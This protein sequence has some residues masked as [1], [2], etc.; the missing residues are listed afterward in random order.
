MNRAN[1]K[2]PI[3]LVIVLLFI[4]CNNDNNP[5]A[6]E[7]LVDYAKKT[8]LSL[9]AIKAAINNFG[10]EDMSELAQYDIDV[11][12]INYYT[13]Y[14]GNKIIVSGVISVPFPVNT[15]LPVLAAHR[16][17][18]FAHDEAP[19]K[20]FIISGYEIFS[21][22][23]FV[24]V[25]PDMIGFGASEQYVHPYYNYEYSS[26]CALDMIRAGK[27]FM[28]KIKI[29]GSKKLFL[30]GYS[31]GGY[32][33]TAAHKALEE[34]G[35]TELTVTA[36][37]TGAGSYNPV[38]VMRD[39]AAREIFTSPSYLA[40]IIY[41]YHDIYNW[42]T[43]LGDFFRQPF[44][45]II[46]YILNG[47]LS[48]YEINAQLNDTL[49]LLFEPPFLASIVSGDEVLLTPALELNRVDNWV[50]EF[51]MRIYHSKGDQYIPFS[52][53]QIMG[54]T[55]KDNGGNVEFIEI[56]GGSHE[57]AGREMVR[58]A[59]PWFSDLAD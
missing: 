51:P 38:G 36:S 54:Q 32:I 4:S 1:S 6:D 41:T 14:K 25:I 27:E 39:I 23:G 31:E 30:F 59:L 17:T 46:P 44:V 43:P 8:S 19:S 53:S 45:E 50:P 10:M 37:A 29:S 58:E 26:A 42:Q 33:T 7:Y 48:S 22:M 49:D 16:G 55:M 3:A 13:N 34:S 35:D 56:P 47:A 11:Y 24:T 18:I 52:D 2:F 28:K 15:E 12:T 57:E 9:T 5:P 20:Q 21:S 40:F